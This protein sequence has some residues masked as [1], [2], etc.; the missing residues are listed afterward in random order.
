MCD[1]ANTAC[2]GIGLAVVQR[3]VAEADLERD[4]TLTIVLACRNAGKACDA[5]MQLLALVPSSR[6][7]AVDI[8]T[9]LCDL[10]NVKQVCA[11]AAEF[12]RRF[13]RLDALVCNAG[14]IPIAGISLASGMVQFFRDPADF[15]KSTAHTIKQQIGA[16]V[17]DGDG[18][19]FGAAFV[20]NF[21]GH[22]IFLREVQGIMADTA[23][24][25][26][27]KRATTQYAR[28]VWVTSDTVM[29]KVFD[30]AD[31]QCLRGDEPYESSKRLIEI[32]HMQ[33]FAELKKSGII[34]VVANPGISATDITQGRVPVFLI[35]AVLYILRLFGLPRVCITPYNAASSIVHLASAVKDPESLDPDLVCVSDV[36]VFG[37][38]RVI[39]YKLDKSDIRV[40]DGDVCTLGSVDAEEIFEYVNDKLKAVLGR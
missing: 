13:K 3:L 20:A 7:G 5:Q 36:N 1:T 15:A 40:C 17:S 6:R 34:S 10:S 16:T 35:I 31:I 8:Q 25:L 23:R 21:F 22:Y 24:F 9:L 29:P 14:M 4:S 30:S 2:S 39:T 32:V 12:K 28:V 33:T 26:R 19:T 11:A 38:Q 37:K 18:G 27:S